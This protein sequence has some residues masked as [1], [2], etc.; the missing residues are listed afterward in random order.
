M[1]KLLRLLW[2]VMFMLPAALSAKSVLFCEPAN[3]CAPW[4]VDALSQAEEEILQS[5]NKQ[6]FPNLLAYQRMPVY[7][8]RQQQVNCIKAG[9]FFYHQPD[10][11]KKLLVI[12]GDGGNTALLM[13]FNSSIWQQD[14]IYFTRGVFFIDYRLSDS[15]LVIIYRACSSV[16]CREKTHRINL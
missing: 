3:R 2:V 15:A 8:C 13:A 14:D 9:I 6:V 5:L 1:M 16:Y 11:G 7:F 10:S 12:E 4:N